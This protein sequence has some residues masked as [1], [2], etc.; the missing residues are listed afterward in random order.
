MM[1][2][3][4]PFPLLLKNHLCVMDDGFIALPPAFKNKPLC[5]MD[6]GFIALP[7]RFSQGTHGLLIKARYLSTSFGKIDHIL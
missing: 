2:S 7:P 4:L 5:V 3:L 6:D 1:I